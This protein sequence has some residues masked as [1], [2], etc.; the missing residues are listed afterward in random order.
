M[1]E[2]YSLSLAF[3]LLFAQCYRDKLCD[4][5]LTCN[6]LGMFGKR[7]GQ[8]LTQTST[9]TAASL[10]ISAVNEWALSLGVAVIV[11]SNVCCEN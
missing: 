3:V 10:M 11:F 5:G 6:E 9:M 2:T 4:D 1:T 7:C 8:L